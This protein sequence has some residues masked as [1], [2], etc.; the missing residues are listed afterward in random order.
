MKY[1]TLLL[2]FTF[3]IPCFSQDFKLGKVSSQELKMTR[4]E[5]DTTAGA[6]ILSSYGNA[7]CGVAPV[8]LPCIKR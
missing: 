2:L 8:N 7:S 5:A 1:L 6:V 4:Y 3:S